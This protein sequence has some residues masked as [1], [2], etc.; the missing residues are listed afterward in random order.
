MTNFAGLKTQRPFSR[1]NRTLGG[2]QTHVGELRNSPPSGIKCA[3]GPSG[4][5]DNVRD[6]KEANALK[7]SYYN[8]LLAHP[9][10]L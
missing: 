9:K 7:L 2:A 3:N 5:D 8:Q 10:S 1:N 6:K 4:N